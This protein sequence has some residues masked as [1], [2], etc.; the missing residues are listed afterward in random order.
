MI[1]DIDKRIIGRYIKMTKKNNTKRPESRKIGRLV[2][3]YRICDKGRPKDKP[4]Y[5]T[6]EKCLEN[7]VKAFPL[8]KVV[9]RVIADNCSEE[10]YSM[11]LRYIPKEQV[12]R[13]SIGSGAGTFRMACDL[14]LTYNDSDLVYFLEDD[15][16]HLPNSMEVLT[17]AAEKNFAD[18]LTL[19]DHPD[20]YGFDTDNPYLSGGGEN[21]ILLW[22]GNHHWKYTN[23]TTMTFAAFVDTIR[24]DKNIYWR[25]TEGYLPS[26]FHMFVNLQ[27]QRSAKLISPVPSLSTH[28]ENAY[29]AKG[30][31]WSKI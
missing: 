9:W 25:W 20:K 12:D 8:E 26:D 19:F 29:L 4:E 6:K 15:Y 18:Y 24:R 3:I 2:V 22:L 31:D 14:A 21:T 5:V 1:F 11:I 28:G 27:L 23:S 17:E 16:L 13:V 10:T 30:I 7:A